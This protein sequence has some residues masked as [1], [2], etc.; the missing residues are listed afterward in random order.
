LKRWFKERWVSLGE[1]DDYPVY[2]PTKRISKQTP[3]TI[4]EIDPEQIPRQIS[5]KQIIKGE[6]NLPKW[7]PAIHSK[8]F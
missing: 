1:K 2:R 7:N 4:H 6:A 5:L 3:L 8:D